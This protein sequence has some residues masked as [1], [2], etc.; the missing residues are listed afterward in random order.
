MR[1]PIDQ[2]PND[3]ESLKR[4]IIE[5]DAQVQ[6]NRD[7]LHLQRLLIEKLK[8]QIARFKRIQFGRK[9]E[10][11]DERIA[12]LEL[13]VEE[14]EA[15]LPEADEPAADVTEPKDG[16]AK[17]KPA[18]RPLADHLPRTTQEHTPA[19]GCPECG[20]A[21]RRIGEDVS[22]QLEFVPEHFKVIR[23]VR[24][25]MSCP[26]CSTVVQAPMP[27]RPIPKGI[28]GPGL[29]AHV[30]VSKYLD[31]LPLYRQSEIYARQ[32]VDL[33]RSTMA[34]WIGA[35][36]KLVEPLVDAVGRYV[37]QAGKVHADDTP[38]PV[39][40]PGRGKTKTA[41]LW[42]YVRDDRPAGSADPPA[43]WYRYTKTG[44][45]PHP[46]Q[47]L[48]KFRGVLQADAFA[49]FNGLY[50][51][52]AVVEA[53]CWAHARRKYFELYEDIKSPIAA[54]ALERIKALYAVENPIEASHQICAARF[55]KSWPPRFLSSCING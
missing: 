13:L 20:T 5:R 25:K 38:V 9:S 17:D 51:S 8:L 47:H 40:D 43:A 19:C 3:V 54:E 11:H 53:A 22:E 48:A 24:P 46:R 4:L 49:G 15:D 7:E 26:E 6:A 42:V 39:L 27:S 33:D 12:Q 32:G 37:K 28:A 30:A 23:T 18:R 52:G 50:E 10:R 35:I 34:G 31:H 2:L 1:T 29:L 41:R 45:G 14:L 36:G 55:V 44:E 16:P 21:L